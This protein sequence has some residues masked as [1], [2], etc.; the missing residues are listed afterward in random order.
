MAI[1]YFQVH[2]TALLKFVFASA[3][4]GT[5]RKPRF[6]IHVLPIGIED[7]LSLNHW[8]AGYVAT[9]ALCEILALFGL[10]LRF[11]GSELQQSALFYVGGFVLI[12][13][14]GPR[15]PAKAPSA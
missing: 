10:V 15:L 9:Y 12:A 7:G 8:R 5:I 1:R 4:K 3:V 2:D 14:F 11:R 6:A 13:F